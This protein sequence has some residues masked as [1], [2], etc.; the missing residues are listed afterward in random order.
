VVGNAQLKPEA[1]TQL[2]FLVRYQTEKSLLQINFYRAMISQYIT[3]VVDPNLKP[4]IATSPGVRKYINVEEA[5]MVGFEISYAQQIGRLFNQDIS[6]AYVRGQNRVLQEPLPEINPFELRYKLVA[7]L[8][9]TKLQP[10]FN[11]RHSFAQNRVSTSFNEKATEDFMVVDIGVKV[12]ANK[13]LQITTAVN[14]LFDIAYREH[15]SRF[16]RPTLPLNAVGRT[17]VLMLTHQL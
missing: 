8:L 1:N 10:Y 4:I 14:N 2:D 6:L 5:S 17:W 9:N 13:K 16:I 3:T 7:Q 11:L 12:L 15:L